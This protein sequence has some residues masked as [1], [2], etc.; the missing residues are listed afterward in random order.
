MIAHMFALQRRISAF[1]DP[2]LEEDNHSTNDGGL[3]VRDGPGH[4]SNTATKIKFRIAMNFY[5]R[6]QYQTDCQD[7]NGI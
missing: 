1:A 5:F 6:G 4:K 2:D 3:V 7:P